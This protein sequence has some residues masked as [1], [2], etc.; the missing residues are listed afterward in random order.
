MR[1]LAKLYIFL[2]ILADGTIC[3]ALFPQ[4]DKCVDYCSARTSW[5]DFF[6]WNIVRGIKMRNHFIGKEG[7]ISATILAWYFV[8]GRCA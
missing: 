6:S 2:T 7:L 8:D 3:W 4:L 1:A 5:V